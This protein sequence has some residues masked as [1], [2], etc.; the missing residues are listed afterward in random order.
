ML[1][2]SKDI[3]T[4]TYNKVFTKGIQCALIGGNQ[5]RHF[6]VSA[7][8]RD[9]KDIGTEGT[10]TEKPKNPSKNPNRYFVM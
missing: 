2:A 9:T 5:K 3:G 10:F 8:T 4:P 7:F 1:K 6:N